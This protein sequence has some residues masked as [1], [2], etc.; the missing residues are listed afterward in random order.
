MEISISYCIVVLFGFIL[1]KKPNSDFRYG[2]VNVSVKVMKFLPSHD[3][4]H[5]MMLSTVS[6]EEQSGHSVCSFFFNV[7]FCHL[8]SPVEENRLA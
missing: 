4:V 2:T 1:F 3:T 7:E 6:L 5:G 8:T